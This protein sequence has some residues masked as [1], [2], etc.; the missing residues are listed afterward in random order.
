MTMSDRIDEFERNVEKRNVEPQIEWLCQR[1]N[2]QGTG[3]EGGPDDRALLE[4]RL[5]VIGLAT[6]AREA[7]A[8]AD[9]LAEAGARLSNTLP[10]RERPNCFRAACLTDRPACESAY[11]PC[12]NYTANEMFLL[13]LATRR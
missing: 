2:V 8:R 11:Q 13:A 10:Y 7:N 9:E 1:L 4:I 5:A 6:I 3:Y 12:C